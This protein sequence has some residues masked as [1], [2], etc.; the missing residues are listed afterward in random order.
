MTSR[1]SWT[2]D[3]DRVRQEPDDEPDFG[4]IKN[5]LL[6]AVLIVTTCPLWSYNEAIQERLVKCL[7]RGLRHPKETV[8]TLRA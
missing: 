7:G 1:L 5:A 2:V 4:T 3:T 6:A 8:S